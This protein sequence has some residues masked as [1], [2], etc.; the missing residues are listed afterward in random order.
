MK[1]RKLTRLEKIDGPLCDFV[2][3]RTYSGGVFLCDRTAQYEKQLSRVGFRFY[4]GLHLPEP[5]K[6]R[7]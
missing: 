3:D 2:I 7:A 1:S 6:K 5:K 4:C